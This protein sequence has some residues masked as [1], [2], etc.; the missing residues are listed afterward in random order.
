[1]ATDSW[2]DIIIYNWGGVPGV[3]VPLRHHREGSEARA[4]ARDAV[5]GCR[6]DSDLKQSGV[7]A[8]KPPFR[9]GPKP[10]VAPA[11]A[12]RSAEPASSQT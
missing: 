7:A 12:S 10:K 8:L 6:V 5:Q 1:M 4:D 2:D 11:P 9:S 3:M